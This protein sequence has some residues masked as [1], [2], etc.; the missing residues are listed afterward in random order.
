M[1]RKLLKILSICAFCLC[2]AWFLARVVIRLALDPPPPHVAVKSRPVQPKEALADPVVSPI[3]TIMRRNL[4]HALLERPAGADENSGDGTMTPEEEA[5]MLAEMDK[6]PVSKQGW[7]LLG[8]VVNTLVPRESRA[9]LLV[10]GK[11]SPLT[12]GSELKGWKIAFIERRTVVVEKGDR[13]ERLL[14]GQNQKA[15][16]P[17][18][19]DTPRRKAGLDAREV[20]RALSDLPGL[21][22][23]VGFSPDSQDGKNGLSLTFLKPDSFLARLGLRPNDLLLEANGQPLSKLGDLAAFARLARQD[24]IKIEL[25]RNG[26]S[27]VI[28]YDINR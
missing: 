24:S 14:V 15:E 13:R 9:I 2:A 10:D 21:L 18:A 28:E 12:V 26:S 16:T 3:E 23:Q 6:L 11:Q 17:K 8:T 1:A 25:L 20:E 27:V 7:T 4:F 19:V 5:R 22:S